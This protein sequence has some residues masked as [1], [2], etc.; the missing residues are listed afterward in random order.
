MKFFQVENLSGILMLFRALSLAV[1]PTIQPSSEAMM[2]K[3]M[4]IKEADVRSF[5]EQLA[6]YKLPVGTS[7]GEKHL[8]AIIHTDPLGLDV[9]IRWYRSSVQHHPDV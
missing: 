1:G 6:A 8:L 4:L 2:M 9:E 5:H 3:Q 7:N